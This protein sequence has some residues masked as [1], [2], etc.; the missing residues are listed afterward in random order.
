MAEGDGLDVVVPGEEGK[1]EDKDKNKKLDAGAGTGE[2]TLEEQLA[3]AKATLA[4][5]RTARLEAEARARD[6]GGRVVQS[7]AEVRQ[8][9]ITTMNSALEVLTQQREGLK[10]SYSAAMAAGDFD[11]AAEINDASL[12]V[13]SKINE[14]ARGKIMAEAAAK[15]PPARTAGRTAP[16]NA[17]PLEKKLAE[18]DLKPKSEAWVRAHPEYALDPDMTMRMIGA[19]NI[20]ISKGLES[21]SDGYFKFVERYLEMAA[22]DNV[23]TTNGDAA[24][25]KGADVIVSDAGKTVQARQSGTAERDVQPS[26]A[27]ASRGSANT[28]TVRLTPEQQ[29]AA[30]ISGLT[31]EEYARNLLAEKDRNKQQVH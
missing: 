14:I 6:A 17:S 25:G 21:E 15:E 31:N 19:H 3:E 23:G 13:I 18:W 28:R 9:H 12:E 2:K 22:K 20:A 7:E 29:D 4:G 27:P 10:A 1:D 24:G 30:K 16:A 11:K 8:S 26:P 5:E